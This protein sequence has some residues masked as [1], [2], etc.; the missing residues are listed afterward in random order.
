M[1]RFFLLSFF[2]TSMSLG[3]FCQ[4]KSLMAVIYQASFRNSV[5]GSL[6]Y[7]QMCLSVGRTTSVFYSVNAAKLNQ[8]RDSVRR[9]GGDM[10]GVAGSM[11]TGHVHSGQTFVVYK[12]MSSGFLTLTDKIGREQVRCVEDKGCYSWTLCRRDTVIAGFR[13]HLATTLFRGRQWS[14]WYAPDLAVSDGPWKFHGLPGL[15]LSVSDA[16]GDFSFSV[17]SIKRGVRENIPLPDSSLKLCSF[18]QLMDYYR[19]RVENPLAILRNVL[20]PGAE[21]ILD[22]SEKKFFSKKR[23]ACLIEIFE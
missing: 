10:S 22:E 11:M 3:V 5:G 4:E 6:W 20:P 14:A 8:L 23:T 13:C 1:K 12:D 2:L 19:L 7:D 16:A 17:L 9:S 18:R 15:I 21:I